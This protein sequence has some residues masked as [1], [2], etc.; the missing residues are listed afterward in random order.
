HPQAVDP[1]DAARARSEVLGDLPDVPAAAERRP[2]FRRLVD[3]RPAEALGLVLA[4][5]ANRLFR[6]G[7]VRAPVL[8]RLAEEQAARAQCAGDH[9]HTVRPASDR[10]CSVV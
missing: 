5:P 8:E 7:A 6:T 9:A 10:P 2:A 1:D 3:P 4:E